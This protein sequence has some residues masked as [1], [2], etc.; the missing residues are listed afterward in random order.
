MA[1]SMKRD[2]R[3]LKYIALM[4][5][6]SGC[7]HAAPAGRETEAI[8]QND[9][10]GQVAMAEDGT[11]SVEMYP[12]V[13]PDHARLKYRKNDPDYDYIIAQADGLSVGEQKQLYRAVGWTEMFDDRSI[14]VN[15]PGSNISSTDAILSKRIYPGDRD[16]GYYLGL[17][18]DLLPGHKSPILAFRLAN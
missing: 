4:V 12:P 8:S 17:T 3:N 6:M 1:A 14:F 15:L 16:Y 5:I 7:A 18:P 11:I 13:H 2:R 9:Y 10:I